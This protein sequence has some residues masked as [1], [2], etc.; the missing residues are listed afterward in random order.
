[1]LVPE[2]RRGVVVLMNAQNTLDLFLG[3]RMQ[4][5]ANGVTSL[6]EGREPPPPPSN[7]AIFLVYAFVFG[8]MVLQLRGMI[9][10]VNTLRQG[11]VPRGRIGPRWRIALSLAL[12]LAWALLVLVLLPRQLGVS[13]LVV[14]AQPYFPDLTY[15]LVVSAVVALGWGIVRAI[16]AYAVLR[17]AESKEMAAHVPTA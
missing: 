6:L 8:I 3:D 1:V 17:K 15:L 13:L 14:V 2:S 12:S 11:R 9:R 10:S 7:T 4:T 5:I 16:W